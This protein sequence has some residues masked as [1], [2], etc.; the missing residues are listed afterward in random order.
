MAHH[1]TS[2]VGR[3]AYTLTD[4]EGYTARP[5]RDPAGPVDGDFHATELATKQLQATAVARLQ[6]SIVD[7]SLFQIR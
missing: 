7:G 4:S 1:L 3:P 5:H 2:R 6:M